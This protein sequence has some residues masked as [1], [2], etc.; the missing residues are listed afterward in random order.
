MDTLQ[1]LVVV[2]KDTPHSKKDTEHN[3]SDE[4]NINTLQK[5]SGQIHPCH[6]IK[7]RIGLL[8]I[9]ARSECPL[10]KYQHC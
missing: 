5:I 1:Q 9:A 10:Q 6:H 8:Y 2:E 7:N 4:E 3:S